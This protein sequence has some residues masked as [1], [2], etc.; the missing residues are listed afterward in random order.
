V[1]GYARVMLMCIAVDN[2]DDDELSS[3]EHSLLLCMSDVDVC[4]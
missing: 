3:N 4:R 1:Y 2:E